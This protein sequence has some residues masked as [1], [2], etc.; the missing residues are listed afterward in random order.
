MKEGQKEMDAKLFLLWTNKIYYCHN[1]FILIAQLAFSNNIKA[2]EGYVCEK[3]H[4]TKMRYAKPNLSMAM[5][6]CHQY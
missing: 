2:R 1:K 6:E 3:E 5:K 4:L